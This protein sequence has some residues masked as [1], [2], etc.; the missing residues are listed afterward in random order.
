MDYRIPDADAAPPASPS[1]ALPPDPLQD[2]HDRLRILCQRLETAAA[3]LL[4]LRDKLQAQASERQE[5]HREQRNGGAG[6][7]SPEGEEDR[8]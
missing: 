7:G 8:R 3:S 4:R 2:E 1:Q 5:P 6:A